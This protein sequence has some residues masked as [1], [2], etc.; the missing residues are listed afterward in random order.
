VNI[1]MRLTIAAAI[2]AIGLCA[3]ILPC[4]SGNLA[5]V[6]GTTCDIGNLQFT[7][8]GLQSANTAGAP[9]TDADF[10]FTALPNGFTLSGPPAQSLTNT[11]SNE[12]TDYVQLN[13][14]V[15]DLTDA[16]T[17][18]NVFG[19]NTSVSGPDTSFPFTSFAIY[20]DLLSCANSPE[21]PTGSPQVLYGLNE[22]TDQGGGSIE[23]LQESINFYGGSIISGSGGAEEFALVA[24][25]GDSA[26]I[27]NT[28]TIFTFSTGPYIPPPLPSPEPRLLTVLG[29]A[30]LG[31]G[32]A[33]RIK[34]RK[35]G[36]RPARF[37]T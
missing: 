6:D 28:T 22:M 31:L 4:V 5:T 33:S 24:Q 2:T 26:S 17:G 16:I 36:P 12:A 9:W 14:D 37:L 13:Y 30:V 35:I 21:C 23:H 1:A 19:G 3:D 29:M 20:A 34:A 11:G 8:T 27:D 25:P 18:V 7:F 10:F 32:F 15:T